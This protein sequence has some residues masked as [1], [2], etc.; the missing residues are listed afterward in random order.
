[1]HRLLH[2][3]RV[4]L[5]WFYLVCCNLQAGAIIGWCFR[6]ELW[7]TNA[8]TFIN[9]KILISHLICQSKAAFW[10]LEEGDPTYYWQTINSQINQ[11][12]YQ[13]QIIINTQSMLGLSVNLTILHVTW[14]TPGVWVLSF[15]IFYFFLWQ[16]VG[17]GWRIKHWHEAA[18][19]VV[20]EML[21]Y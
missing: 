6:W 9:L 17:F 7:V 5:T 18:S 2:Q 19:Q 4:G 11:I 3:I 12:W 21:D 1:M 13:T 14:V 15:F 8:T 16:N 20:C 10:Q